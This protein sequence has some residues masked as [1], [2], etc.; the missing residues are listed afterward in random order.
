VAPATWIAPSAEEQELWNAQQRADREAYVAALAGTDV[1]VPRPIEGK[2]SKP[3]ATARRGLHIVLPVYT[4]GVLPDRPPKGAY[5][6]NRMFPQWVRDL[7]EQRAARQL[8]INAGTPL[9]RELNVG[10]AASWVKQNPQR[11]K[12]LSDLR[13][14]IRTL[15]NEPLDGDLA[16]GLAC[17]AH[18]SVMNAVPWNTMSHPYV[19]Y[20][21]ERDSL[22]ALWL[23]DC[24]V[25]WQ[26]KSDR[27]LDREQHPWPA[28]LV[29]AIRM[30]QGTHQST[31]D[32]STD[33]ANLSEAVDS[34]C[35]HRGIGATMRSDM[36]DISQWIPRIESW[37]RRD[38]LLP[39]D[40]IVKTQSVFHW[41]RCIN[42]ARQGIAC[43]YCDRTTAEQIIEHAGRLCARTYPDWREL[44]AAYII[45][46]VLQMGRDGTAE[47]LY[48]QSLAQHARLMQDPASPW[49]RFGL[50]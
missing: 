5:W 47:T 7:A 13:G 25:D 2:D 4:R 21:A 24:A 34:W 50:R 11:V 30:D 37:M 46:R 19:E 20:K 42:M 9:E 17:N 36:A 49:V 35:E 27:L 33:T 39:P 48:A 18:L 43:A 45:G 28:D 29:F 26:N 3:Y 15:F 40:G 38:D 44:S 10:R 23:I 8:L 41:A 22:K 16:R 14:R 6:D 32:V 1:F 12:H 31:G